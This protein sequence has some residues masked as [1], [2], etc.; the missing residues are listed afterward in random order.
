M[1]IMYLTV[2]CRRTGLSDET[3]GIWINCGY[4]KTRSRVIAPG[5]GRDVY[6][7]KYRGTY[8]FRFGITFI[9]TVTGDRLCWY[10]R[11]AAENSENMG[12]I[13]S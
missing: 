9:F 12:F 3:G 13:K 6:S 11:K 1:Q 7:E 2:Q 8:R 4:G 10:V 5:A